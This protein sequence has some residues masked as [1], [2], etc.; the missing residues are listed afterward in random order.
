MGWLIVRKHPDVIKYGK[1]VSM[2]DLEADPYIMFQH[3]HFMNLMYLCAIVIPVFIPW[4]FW[5]EPFMTS[6]LYAGV[7][8]YITSLHIT[9]LINSAAHA[10]GMKPF[11]RYDKKL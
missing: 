9:W 7:F 10:Y 6:F 4:F 11:D 8:R 1:K 5:N 2:A 3:K